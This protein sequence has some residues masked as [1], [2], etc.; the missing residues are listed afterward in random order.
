MH[1]GEKQHTDAN[2]KKDKSSTWVLNDDKPL[3]SPGGA[4]TSQRPD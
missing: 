4:A 1:W 3:P 2:S